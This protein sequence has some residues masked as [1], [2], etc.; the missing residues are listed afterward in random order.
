MDYLGQHEYILPVLPEFTSGQLIRS[1]L[2][3]RKT[4]TGQAVIDMSKIRMDYA[5]HDLSDRSFI[6]L[7]YSFFTDEAKKEEKTKKQASE[8]VADGKNQVAVDYTK[9][10]KAMMQKTQDLI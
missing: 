6:C 8:A 4:Y 2:E 3:K 1:T 5:R 7:D 10:S 9:L